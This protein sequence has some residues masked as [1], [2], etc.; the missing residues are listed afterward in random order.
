MTAHENKTALPLVHLGITRPEELS[1]LFADLR[2]RFD[3][4]CASAHDES[5]WKQF[6][7]AWLGRKSGV[8]TQ[9]TDNWL[10]P[11]TLELKRAVGASLNELRAHVESQI[12]TRRAAIESGSEKPPWQV[13]ESTSLSPA[14]FAPSAPIT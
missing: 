3:N 11:A 2:G 1:A 4:D 7:D 9:I 13:S 8:L 5:S 10:K 12:E 14:S 6:R